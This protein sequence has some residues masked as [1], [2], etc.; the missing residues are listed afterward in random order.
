M[1]FRSWTC[2]GRHQ[3]ELCRNLRSAGIIRSDAVYNVMKD[4][5]RQFYMSLVPSAQGEASSSF[6]HHQQHDCPVYYVDAPFPIGMGQTI[7]APHMHAHVLEDMLPHLT[8][9]PL[10]SSSADDSSNNMRLLDVGCGSGYLTACLGRWCR[11]SKYIGRTGRVFGIDIQTTLVDRTRRNI[12]S[13]DASLLYYDTDDDDNSPI[14]QLETANGW[15]GLPKAAPFDGIHVGAAAASFPK[16]LA[17][18]LKLGGVMIV[19][20]GPD[21]GA[22]G[23]YK[24]VREQWADEFHLDD[25]HVTKLLDVR[26]VPLVQSPVVLAP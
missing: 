23:L 26:Y 25:F 15:N 24:V 3:R 2:H 20:I 14:V 11:D 13:D 17:M 16:K 18:Q 22:Q 12:K 19:P 10:M 5:D 21:G 1:P 4:T 9:P 8:S 7:S 6:H